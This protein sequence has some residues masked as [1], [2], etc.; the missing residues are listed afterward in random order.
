MKSSSNPQCNGK[1]REKRKYLC[2]AR[3]FFNPTPT[4][5]Q[6]FSHIMFS[7]T[8]MLLLMLGSTFTQA[9]V[10]D[11]LPRPTST[12]QH[13]VA[14]WNGQT[15][16]D[17]H[18]EYSNIFK[19]GNRNAASHRLS[20]FLLDRAPNSFTLQTLTYMFTGFCAVSGSPI[21]PNDYNRYGLAL[22]S[23][24]NGASDKMFGFMHYCCWP[25]VCDTQDFIKVDTKNITFADGATHQLHFAVIGNPCDHP[26]AL[27][28]PFV[29]PFDRRT[30]TLAREAAEVRCNADGSL[31]GATMS[32]HGYVIISMFFDAVPVNT[33]D[34]QSVTTSTLGEE[35]PGR[36]QETERGI[37]YQSER[38][39]AGMCTN[40][41][42]NG[43]N[44][45]MGEIF[46][47]VASISAIDRS[48]RGGNGA[49]ER[50]EMVVGGEGLHR[51]L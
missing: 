20:T 6:P 50:G 15:T 40:R 18:R 47:K 29:Q 37:K 17:L 44:S 11:I 5:N 10:V 38:E 34:G 31:E 32:D 1:R 33:G 4:N 45:G 22:D 3:D 39:Y 19:Y 8:A 48:K 2:P 7:H 28:K 27:E 23:L 26:E 21:T 43:Y 46:R 41:A 36:V 42:N 14:P 30:T 12:T 35:T 49:S 25:C 13:L 16:R 51:E 24:T 9:Q